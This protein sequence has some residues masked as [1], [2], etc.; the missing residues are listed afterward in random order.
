[1]RIE[2][3]AQRIN[4]KLRTKGLTLSTAE[5]CT[6]GGIAAAITSIPGSSDI[7]KGGIVAYANEAKRS[8]LSVQET[9]LQHDGAV[10]EATVQQ[11]AVGVARLMQTECAIATSGIAGPGGGTTEKP[12]GT[13]WLAVLVSGE[14]HTRLLKLDD[15]GRNA[16]IKETIQRALETLLTLLDDN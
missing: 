15:K 12:V 11:M 3:L 1:M 8:V 7:F 16:N 5:S 14:T 6:G 9:T 13:V 10:S 2:Q 4:D